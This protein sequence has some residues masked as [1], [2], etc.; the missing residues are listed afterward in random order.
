MARQRGVLNFDSDGQALVGRARK[1]HLRERRGG[2]RR[3]LKVCERLLH[4]A[5]QLALYERAHFV[6]AHSGCSVLACGEH[7]WVLRRKDVIQR[8]HKLAELG[9][10]PAVLPAHVQHPF[11][12]TLV[13]LRQ[14]RLPLR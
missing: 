6:E 3:G 2:D 4:A 13:R 11:G 1:V 8:G 7:L 12:G 10:Q 5:A 14:R 9:V